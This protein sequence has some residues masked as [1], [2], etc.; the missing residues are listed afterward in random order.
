VDIVKE[1]MWGK[2]SLLLARKREASGNV[3]LYAL[4]LV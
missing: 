3:L 2:R 4:R 1:R